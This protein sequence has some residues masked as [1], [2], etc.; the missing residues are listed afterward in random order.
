MCCLLIFR[1][2]MHLQITIQCQRAKYS[3]NSPHISAS[4]NIYC[5]NA[6]FYHYQKGFDTKYEDWPL[7]TK[8][9]NQWTW[10]N[11]PTR[12]S[13]TSIEGYCWL[14]QLIIRHLL[15]TE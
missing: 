2:G 14:I 11:P 10:N 8:K 7:E 9:A 13:K 4:F 1:R 15:V 5:L 12:V 6:I 3:G